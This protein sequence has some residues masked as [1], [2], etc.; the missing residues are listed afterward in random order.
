MVIWEL[1][2]YYDCHI[3]CDFHFL[4]LRYARQV[5]E[6][7]EFVKRKKEAQP[8]QSSED[9]QTSQQKVLLPEQ[10]GLWLPGGKHF[11]GSPLQ[12]LDFRQAFSSMSS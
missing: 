10:G 9:N 1:S 4:F 7:F 6:F 5:A 11:P 12:S 3:L 8:P 2:D